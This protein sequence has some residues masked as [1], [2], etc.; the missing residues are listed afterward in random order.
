MHHILK[1]TTLKTEDLEP[2]TLHEDNVVCIAQLKGGY[3]KDDRM[4][5]ISPKFFYTHEL[6]KKGVISM[7]QVQSSE[8]FIEL[9]TKS[10]PYVNSKAC[11]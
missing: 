8:N 11:N 5:Y 10:F 4:K 7:K 1:T 3:I 9:S 6:Q 2:T